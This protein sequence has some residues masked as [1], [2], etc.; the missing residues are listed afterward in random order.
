MICI[1]PARGNSQRIPG[2][3]MK[4]FHGKPMIQHSI[5][6]AKDSHLFDGILVTTDDERT[7]DLAE[8][9]HVGVI[10]RSPEL[11]EDDI[12]TQQVAKEALKIT[13]TPEDEYVM[14]LYA[15]SPL[16]DWSYVKTA[17]ELLYTT[18]FKYAMSVDMKGIDA[19]NFYISKAK[20]FLADVPLE[21]NSIQIGME[22]GRVCDI[23]TKEDWV[24]AEK[25]YEEI[26]NDR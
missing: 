19:G 23:N 20:N 15:T 3:N 18:D 5:D 21:G 2:K 25:M 8:R 7:I 16:L 22:P 4:M 17:I 24:K 10:E 1:I 13:G 14:V 6:A 26:H 12:G 9:L 11:C